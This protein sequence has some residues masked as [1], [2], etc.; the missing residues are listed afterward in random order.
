MTVGGALLGQPWLAKLL[1]V[2][3]EASFVE[4]GE[5]VGHGI[6]GRLESTKTTLIVL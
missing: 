2:M 1:L 6:F 5:G 3:T 4:D